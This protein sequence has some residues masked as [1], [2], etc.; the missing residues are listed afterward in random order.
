MN[1]IIYSNGNISGIVVWRVVHHVPQNAKLQSAAEER[2][3]VQELLL[4]AESRESVR[5]LSRT[6]EIK[7]KMKNIDKLPG[8]RKM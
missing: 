5:R 3:L 1:I 7:G 4:R 6:G 2:N 8:R